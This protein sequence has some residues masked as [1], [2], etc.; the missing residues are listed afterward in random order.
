[1]SFADRIPACRIPAWHEFYATVA[2]LAATL[3]NP[4]IIAADGP[5]G[6]R[7]LAAQ[8]VHN[9]LVLLVLL[10]PDDTAHPGNHAAHRRA[11]GRYPGGARSASSSA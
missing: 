5:T 7:V 6:M 10:I 2:G 4:R 8:T 11:A 3:V 9:V 1:V